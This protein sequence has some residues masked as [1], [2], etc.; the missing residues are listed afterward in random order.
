[1]LHEIQVQEPPTPIWKGADQ[2]GGVEPIKFVQPT[3]AERD[4]AHQEGE[5]DC[6]GT[7]EPAEIMT[8]HEPVPKTAFQSSDFTAQ[9]RESV[10]MLWES[11]YDVSAMVQDLLQEPEG[12]NQGDDT[13]TAAAEEDSDSLGE[14]KPADEGHGQLTAAGK[15]RS[16]IGHPSPSERLPVPPCN[17]NI[18]H[19]DGKVAS[20]KA[21]QH[22]MS[23]VHV[24]VPDM[25]H[26]TEQAS[27]E[28]NL[29]EGPLNQL[30]KEKGWQQ[31][32][33]THRFQSSFSFRRSYFSAQVKEKNVV[34]CNVVRLP[35]C[36]MGQ[37]AFYL[38]LCD[39]DH[40]P[41]L[42]A[43][44]VHGK[45]ALAIFTAS[46]TC[47][48]EEVLI[49]E[50][51]G[52]FLGTEYVL[53]EYTGGDG[54]RRLSRTYTAPCAETMT[55][56]Y[57]HNLLGSAGPRKVR[58]ILKSPD[59]QPCNRSSFSMRNLTRTFSVR[60]PTGETKILRSKPAEWNSSLSAYCL[61][62][63]GRVTWASVKNFQIIEGDKDGPVLLQFG[64]NGEHEFALD[65]SHPFSCVQAFALGL[66][67]MY[68]KL[69]CD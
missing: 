67:S 23:Q 25:V 17:G 21:Q 5:K 1:M 38:R 47:A 8:M 19:V 15:I 16:S 54:S 33:A 13:D 4:R 52:N 57:K 11:S 44:K 56:L 18:V 40:T 49:G 53:K 50:L 42:L 9:E 60:E 14:I 48:E 43:R 65:Y 68:R 46:R 12:V 69:A 30:A 20:S 36:K 39:E 27:D 3:E 29:K 51:R 32:A 62:F 45:N 26:E 22:D 31:P 28:G 66:S 58:A 6:T 37:P 7:E 63:K 59:D 55:V 64:K 41:L 24:Q 10:S 35:G 61:N 2:P 34:R